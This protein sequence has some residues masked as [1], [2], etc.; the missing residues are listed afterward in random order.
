MIGTLIGIFLTVLVLGL[1]WW[2][3]MT[4]WPAIA[5]YIAEPFKTIAYVILIVILVLVAIWVIIQLL[6][7]GGIHVPIPKGF[8]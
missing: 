5:Q 4:I 6:A 8:G 1:L 2:A 7:V 3:I